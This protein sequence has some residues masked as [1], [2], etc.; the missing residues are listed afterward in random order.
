VPDQ[1]VVFPFTSTTREDGPLATFDQLY[2]NV[3]RQKVIDGMVI[4]SSAGCVGVRAS[5]EHLHGK[6]IN[7]GGPDGV[8]PLSSPGL[9][10]LGDLVCGFRRSTE[11]HRYAHGDG[12]GYV[13]CSRADTTGSTLGRPVARA[14]LYVRGGALHIDGREPIAVGSAGWWRWLDERPS[15]TVRARRCAVLTTGPSSPC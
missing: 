9:R 6:I 11:R 3:I 8:P 7:G 1:V 14:A 15:T 5:D 13:R 10:H 2:E 4:I 12:F